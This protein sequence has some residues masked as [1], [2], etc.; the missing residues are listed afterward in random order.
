M[1]YEKGGIHVGAAVSHISCLLARYIVYSFL[2]DITP[3]HIYESIILLLPTA[4]IY[5]DISLI[6][7]LRRQASMSNNHAPLC[8][9]C[10][11]SSLAG[12]KNNPESPFNSCLAV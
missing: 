2:N 6:Y 3:K 4:H 11:P 10:G 1:Y 7:A 5:V 8:H 9:R 12:I